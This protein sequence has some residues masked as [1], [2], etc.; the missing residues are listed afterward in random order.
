MR[1]EGGR[2]LVEVPYVL[3]RMGKQVYTEKRSGS[4]PLIEVGNMF[5]YKTEFCSVGLHFK[6]MCGIDCMNV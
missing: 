2:D 6:T 4:V 3:E 5:Q 1:E